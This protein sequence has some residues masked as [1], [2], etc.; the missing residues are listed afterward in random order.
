MP[1]YI[2]GGIEMRIEN[3]GNVNS[4]QNQQN[5]EEKKADTPQKET[6]KLA[7]VYEQSKAEDKGHVYDKMTIDQLK[8][9]SEKAYATLRQIVND[10]LR[11]QGKSLDILQPHDEIQVDETARSEAKELLGR[12]GA[13]G[14]EATSN[15]IVNFAKAISGGDKSKLDALKNAIDKG[16]KEA[17]KILGEL[18][19]IS[20][21]TYD[22]IMEKLDAWEKE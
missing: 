21:K 6:S 16:F 14:I 15:R 4:I 9:D 17:E 1:I 19:E 7:A 5:L 22:M 13:L 2:I 3:T 11:R 10:L 8:K 20:Q 12:N 18:P